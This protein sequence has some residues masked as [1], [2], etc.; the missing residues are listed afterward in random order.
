MDSVIQRPDEKGTAVEPLLS[1][2]KEEK[3]NRVATRRNDLSDEEEPP[4]SRLPTLA[5][6]IAE[7][8]R[9]WLLAFPLCGMYVCAVSGLDQILRIQTWLEFGC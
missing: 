6:F 8:K 4:L 1:S 3:S 9:L 7:S 2:H 5:Q